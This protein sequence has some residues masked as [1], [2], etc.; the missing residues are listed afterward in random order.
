MNIPIVI[1]AYDRPASLARLLSSLTNAEYP[2]END[3]ELIISIDYSGDND[4]RKIAVEFDWTHGKKTV[5]CHK[6][7]LGLREHIIR[8]GDLS[9]NY[10]GIIILEDDLIVSPAFYYY[11][12][13]V[14]RFYSKSER[15]AG[16]SLYSYERNEF[17]DLPYSP[18][19]D[20]KD[21]YFMKVPSSWGQ[22]FLKDHW[23]KFIDSVNNGL[24]LNIEDF[25]PDPIFKWPD[26]SW[27][28]LYFKHMLAND[29]YFVYPID[30]YTSNLGEKGTHY[31]TEVSYLK[32]K[33][34]LKRDN[35][36]FSGYNETYNIYDQFM[37]WE[38]KKIFTKDR[39]FNQWD[40]IEIDLYGTK[41]L[42]K[43]K[44]GAM[45]TS[46]NVLHQ[47]RK[48]PII[49]HPIQ[50]NLL[51]QPNSVDSDSS[52]LKIAKT[53]HVLNDSTPIYEYFTKCTNPSLLLQSYN[54]GI[55]QNKKTRKY[56]LGNFLLSPFQKMVNLVINMWSL[57]R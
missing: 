25:L 33:I 49:F 51:F 50:M 57:K 36:L 35:F 41:P 22:I 53:I 12:L 6:N 9:L 3:I 26:T 45:I 39:K 28:K 32:T 34:A 19:R 29:L 43:I 54:N 21:S 5:I 27:K 31:A 14:S 8:C 15:I 46:R 42:G 20:G 24:D 1:A 11:S 17:C 55:A 44:K 13:E 4:C 52:F 16:I 10:N 47:E 23:L 40:D 38:P 48:I 37:E 18:I 7:H 2:D 56:R 30:S